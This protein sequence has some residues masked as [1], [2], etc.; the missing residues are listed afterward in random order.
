M[1]RFLVILSIL[2]AI[3]VAAGAGWYFFYNKKPQIA[4]IPVV[5]ERKVLF[6]RHPMTPSVTSPAPKE[7]EMGMDY[8]PVYEEEA[9]QG[10]SG[11]VSI[12][13]EK[14]QKIGVK[15]EEVKRHILKRTI[16]TVGRVEHDEARVFNINAKVS[17]W[18]EKLYVNRTDLMVH[19]GEKLLELY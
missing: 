4:E 10:V 11:V 12:S 8:I 5:R 15:S 14:I 9:K 1:R 17:G 16:R 13:P 7:D 6:Y 2:T 3:A 19:P 18:V